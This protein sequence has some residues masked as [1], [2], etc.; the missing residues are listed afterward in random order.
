MQSQAGT[1]IIKREDLDV[2]PVTLSTDGLRIGRLPDCEL[3]LNHPAVSRLHAGL[4]ETGGRFYVFNFSRS[5]G[6]MLNGRIVPAEEAEV[7]ADGD[8][9]QLGPFIIHLEIDGNTLSVRVALQM[10]ATPGQAF[11]SGDIEHEAPQE[12][13]AHEGP[14]HAGS[15]DVTHALGVFW[16]KRKREAGKMQRPSPLRPHAAARV[17][18]KARFNWTPTRDLVRPWPFS[19]FL[20]GFIVVA[21]LSVVAAA[22][23]PQVFSPAP[24]SDAHARSSLTQQPAI[25]RE[26]NAGSCTS[27]HSLTAGM[28]TNCAS[29][30]QAEA[31]SAAITPAHNDAGITCA[32]CHGEHMGAQ[33]HPAAAAAATCLSCHNDANRKLYNGRRV[34]TPHGGG[35]GYPVVAGKWVWRGLDAEEWAEKPPAMR[36]AL[37]RLEETAQRATPA[38]SGDAEQQRSAQFHALHLHR[39]KVAGGLKGNRDGELSCS[40]CHRSFA[41][42]DTATPRT[43]CAVCHQGDPGGTFKGALGSEQANCISCHVQHVKGRQAWSKSLLAG[44]D[45]HSPDDATKT[46][47]ARLFK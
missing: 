8:C 39:V 20:W 44:G 32:N 46:R 28:K 31:F 43:T 45:K 1:F 47:L 38:P 35:L 22:G 16:E 23:Y 21:L 27:C 25:A 18:G 40:S 6:T 24:L 42:I 3:I 15:D 33:F 14:Q 13:H 10:T 17:V 19:V 36:E 12:K 26:A 30:H 29:C 5:N 37:K 7:L 34:G 4:N 2:D 11:A 41:P 9:L